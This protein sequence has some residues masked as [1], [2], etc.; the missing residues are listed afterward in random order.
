MR[1]T[2]IFCAIGFGLVCVISAACTNVTRVVKAGDGSGDGSSTDPNAGGDGSGN[3]ATGD[4]GSG[5]SGGTGSNTPK[6]PP[7]QLVDGLSVKEVAIYQAVK[8][9]LVKNGAL[10][11]HD[12]P[13]VANRDA[14]VRVFVTPDSSWGN[15]SATAQLR[16]LAPDGVT[17]LATLAD[18]KKISSTSTDANLS[19][20]FDFDV[21]AADLPEGGKYDVALTDANASPVADGTK[22]PARFP[23]DGSTTATGAASTGKS[24]RIKIVPIQYMAD[25]SGRLP[26]TSQAQLDTYKR[27]IKNLDPVA[28]VEITV[29]SPWQ[30]SSAIN[31]NGSGVGTVLQRLVQLRQ[32]DNADDDVYYWGAFAP[33][34]SF[35]SYCGGGCVTGLS[36]VL[37]D[38]RDAAARASVGIGYTGEET[39]YTAA[40]EVGHAHGRDH[41]P[42]GGA[43]GIDP[44]FPQSD[45]SIG[46]WGYDLSAKA[47]LDP[48]QTFDMMGY[49]QPEWIS[50]YTYSALFDRIQIVN[51][52]KSIA[53]LTTRFSAPQTYRFVTVNADGS[54]TAGDTT[55]LVQ[56][57]FAEEHDVTYEAADGTAV[58][59]AT[60]HFYKYDHLPG[61]FL[62]VPE[63]TTPYS[64]LAVRMST[65]SVV[66]VAR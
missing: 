21:P 12:T 62:L 30:Y 54:L 40:H 11:Q 25:G 66:R 6:P 20:T 17:V 2:T 1:P 37:T 55:Q 34:S 41:A 27:V 31:G 60:A 16:L 33:T 19:S 45:G 29:R 59:T 10:A 32:Q 51:G 3:A 7:D 46:S 5:G 36:S 8:V 18:T 39:A 24:V 44:S 38:P 47:L 9:D 28:D 64:R 49:C 15:K 52:A 4:D 26:D 13:V 14:L 57:P 61:G 48:S 58:G 65:T 42:C 23:Q 63:T 50:D 43:S 56:R 53:G 35:S 22:S